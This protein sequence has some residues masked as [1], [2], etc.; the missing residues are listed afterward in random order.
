MREI[1]KNDYNVDQNIDNVI[2]YVE[3]YF[4]S[5]P[6]LRFAIVPEKYAGKLTISEF[7]RLKKAYTDKDYHIFVVYSYNDNGAM[8]RDEGPNGIKKIMVSKIP[9]VQWMIDELIRFNE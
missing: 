5:K 7:E 4:E 9:I 1:I 2:L 3:K 8:Y 6:N